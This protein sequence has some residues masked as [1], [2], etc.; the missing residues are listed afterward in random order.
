MPIREFICCSCGHQFEELILSA[1][2]EK[3]LVCPKCGSHKLNRCFSVFGV[4][5]AEKKV[6]TTGSSCS[7]CSSHNCSS[8]G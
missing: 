1:R 6:K 8:C 5:G 3:N 4:S 7:H 2:D